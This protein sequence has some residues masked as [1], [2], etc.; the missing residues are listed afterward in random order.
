MA[1]R[2]NDDSF[3]GI[4]GQGD[5]ESTSFLEGLEENLLQG[6]GVVVQIPSLSFLT[7][8]IK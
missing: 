4:A 6:Y 1:G 7:L 8:N 2:Y 5:G 3:T